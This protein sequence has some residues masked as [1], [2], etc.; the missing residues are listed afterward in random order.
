MYGPI[1]YSNDINTY[2]DNHIKYYVH[3]MNACSGIIMKNKNRDDNINILV[4]KF[5]YI[6]IKII[7]TKWIKVNYNYILIDNNIYIILKY[8]RIDLKIPDINN[9]GVLNIALYKILFYVR[10]II[11]LLLYIINKYINNYIINK[12]YKTIENNNYPEGYNKHNI[13]F[14]KEP[15]L[16]YCEINDINIKFLLFCIYIKVIGKTQKYKSYLIR[17]YVHNK[18][19]FNYEH[20]D[21]NTHNY[22]IYFYPI[23][24]D[25][26]NIVKY[27]K[28]LESEYSNYNLIY[29]ILDNKLLSDLYS[30]I[31]EDGIF[32]YNY[33]ENNS[34][35]NENN[36]N[37]NENNINL[38]ISISDNNIELD[39]Y[40]SLKLR[41]FQQI[42]EEFKNI[43][44]KIL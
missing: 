14:N 31:D 2:T 21:L 26:N 29:S 37:Y 5:I 15:L 40:H 42:S 17:T 16:N 24:Y 19:I 6:K 30:D 13:K 39:F 35:L 1:L 18:S 27:V 44:I 4:N 12:P 41:E 25:I 32:H 10:Y 34:N 8:E 11:T 38:N 3:K 36:C 20:I 9:I 23:D 22:P 7:Y 33:N 28:L 43:I